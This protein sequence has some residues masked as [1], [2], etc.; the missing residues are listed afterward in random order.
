MLITG[1]GFCPV[2]DRAAVTGQEPAVHATS[3]T[4]G[5]IGDLS[6]EIAL[7]S[8]GDVAPI[9]ALAEVPVVKAATRVR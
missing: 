4:H 2:A 7:N 6:L 9:R 3:R 1:E 8:E 5:P